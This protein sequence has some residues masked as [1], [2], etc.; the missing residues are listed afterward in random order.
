MTNTYSEEEARIS[1]D[2]EAYQT[3][4]NKSIPKLAKEIGVDYRRLLRRLRR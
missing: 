4:K 3:G 1:K 2:I